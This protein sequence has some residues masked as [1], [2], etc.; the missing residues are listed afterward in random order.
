M[1]LSLIYPTKPY[2]KN[3]K[4]PWGFYDPANYSQF[5]FT[6]HNGEDFALGNPPE[7]RSP[8]DSEVIRTGNQPKGGGLFAGLLSQQEYDFDDGIKCRVL[9]DFLHCKEIKVKEGDKLKIGDLIAI[10]DNTGFSTGPHTHG[11]YRRV[12][13]D[14]K[15]I[16]TI[17]KNDANNSFDPTPYWSGLYYDQYVAQQVISAATAI[18]SEIPKIPQAQQKTIIDLLSDLLKKVIVFLS[19]K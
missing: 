11:Q 13:W 16:T 6:R 19:G 3:L 15:T 4:N 5:G 10:A 8:F 12:N 9:I 1:R 7:L 2:I 14:G 18:A 17:D